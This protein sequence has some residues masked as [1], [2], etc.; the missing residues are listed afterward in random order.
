MSAKTIADAAEIWIS[1]C[2]LD[3]LE[4]STLRSYRGQLK[5]HI[6]PLLRDTELKLLSRGD[7][8]EFLDAMLAK[9]TRSMTGKVLTSLRSLLSEAVD[10]EWIEY[11]VAKDIKLRNNKRNGYRRVFPEKSELRKILDVVCEKDR[12][13]WTTAIYT[14][15]RLSELRGLSWLNVDFDK[16]LINITQRA[17]ENFKIGRPKSKAGERTIPM[18]PSVRY[19]LQAW[20]LVCPKGPLDLVFPNGVG[21]V[22]S[23][24]NIHTRKWR[25]LMKKAELLNDAGKPKFNIHSLRHAAASL[26]LEQ[27]WPL[28][29]VQ[30]ILGHSSI[31]MTMDVY[32][33]LMDDVANDVSL[34][35]KLENDLV[36]EL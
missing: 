24:A 15:M 16:G 36:S 8:R 27:G 18:A 25:P 19:H 22:E 17:D 11:N 2:E 31:T 3:E 10:R 29:K 6:L 9:S 23:S 21:N 14:G 32:G 26:F 13:F 34:F 5:H 1:R 35:E 30:T 28:K 4:Q 7:V 33:H 12:P 20:K